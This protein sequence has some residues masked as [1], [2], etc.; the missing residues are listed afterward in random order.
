M[1]YT[2]IFKDVKERDVEVII[3]IPDGDVEVV[4]MDEDDSVIRLTKDPVKI[5]GEIDDMF[6]VIETKS[7]DID[8]LVKPY[9]ADMF[10]RNA[11]DIRVNIWR[12][13]RCLFAGFLEPQVFNQPYSK[14]WD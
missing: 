1:I 3:D 9:L 12:E 7:C 10:G 14:S 4:R 13:G 5:N 8:L 2:G 6:Q 11:R